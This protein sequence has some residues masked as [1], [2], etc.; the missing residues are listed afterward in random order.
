M[1]YSGGLG[2]S[3][4]P[5]GGID[6]T[7][8]ACIFCVTALHRGFRF[9]YGNWMCREWVEPPDWQAIIRAPRLGPSQMWSVFV[10]LLRH[11]CLSPVRPSSG[12]TLWCRTAR[13]L[14]ELIFWHHMVSRGQ[15]TILFC[16]PG[17]VIG[18]M[19]RGMPNPRH[20]ESGFET[21]RLRDCPDLRIVGRGDGKW[22]NGFSRAGQCGFGANPASCQSGQA[23]IS[24]GAEQS[25]AVSRGL[26]G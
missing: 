4:Q 24:I 16:M 2:D 17:F 7:E 9:C 11:R 12:I 3:G 14:S 19:E 8:R 26:A 6:P 10:G 22:A 15:N 1:L 21:N 13:R 25:G 5:A 23:F 18:E 20:E